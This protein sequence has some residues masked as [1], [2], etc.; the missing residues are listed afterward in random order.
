MRECTKGCGLL[1][2]TADDREHNCLAELRT[3]IEVSC[4]HC[5]YSSQSAMILHQ[6]LLF[7]FDLW[8]LI[9]LASLVSSLCACTLGCVGD[10]CAAN[11]TCDFCAVICDL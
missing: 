7:S 4:A 1:L 2:L 3:C 9:F 6:S 5:Y 8:L 10:L 11:C